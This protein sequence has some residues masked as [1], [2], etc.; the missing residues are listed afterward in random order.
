MKHG[1]ECL[2]RRGVN[3]IYMK[4]LINFIRN[5]NFEWFKKKNLILRYSYFSLGLLDIPFVKFAS[6]V[7]AIL[8]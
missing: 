5:E 8:L 4:N 2:A 7:V 1:S 3:L 6:V